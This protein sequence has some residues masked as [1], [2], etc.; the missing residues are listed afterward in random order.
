MKVSLPLALAAGAVGGVTTAGITV[1]SLYPDSAT[2]AAALDPLAGGSDLAEEVRGLRAQNARLAERLDLLEQPLVALSRGER[3]EVR[4]PEDVQFEADLRELVTAQREGR[5]IPNLQTSVRAAVETIRAEDEQERQE[6]RRLQQEQRLDENIARL[7][8]KLGLDGYQATQLRGVLT[9]EA[10]KRDEMMAAVRESGDFRGGMR[11]AW[12]T[13][14]EETQTAL[15]QFLTPSQIEQYNE[16][17]PRMGR[18]GFGGGN[19]RGGQGGNQR[20]DRSGG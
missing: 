16:S 3:A 18:R 2:E 19:T 20:G 8:Q 13:L 17:Q 5:P 4:S 6:R 10:L 7:T 11:Q 15:A 1:V 9:N 14:R 12:G